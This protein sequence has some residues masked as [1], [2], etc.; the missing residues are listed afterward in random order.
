MLADKD[1]NDKAGANSVL[2]DEQGK[3]DAVEVLTVEGMFSW[4]AA[5]CMMFW[6]VTFICASTMAVLTFQDQGVERISQE[7]SFVQEQNPP[8]GPPDQPR[9]NTGVREINEAFRYHLPQVALFYSAASAAFGLFTVSFFINTML[10]ESQGTARNVDISL[11]CSQGIEV[12]MLRTFPVIL[13][14]L[15]MTGWYVYMTAGWG[16]LL[17]FCAGAFF[18][19]TSA[20]IGIR[21]TV[22]GTCRLA[23]TMGERLDVSVQLGMRT[24]SIGGLLATSLALGG[25]SIMWFWVLDTSLLSGFS[26]GAA[27]VS[28]YLRVGGGI[29]AKGAEIG[30]D[31]VGDMT[32]NANDED[33]RVFELQQRIEDMEIER[34]NRLA[35]GLEEDEED[36]LDL[37]RM[38]EEEMH[39]IC[40]DMHP[41]DFLDEIGEVICDV[42]GT[43]VDLF[44]SMVLILSTAVIIGAKIA[45]VPHFLTGLPFWIV[46]SG[47]IGCS[48]AAYRVHVTE[49][50]TTQMVRWSMRFNLF[51]IIVFTQLVQIGISYMEWIRGSITFRMFINFVV[52]STMGQFLP[53]MCV[54]SGEYFTSPDY[55]PVKSIAENSKLGVVQVTLQGLGQGFLSTTLPAIFVVIAVMVTWELE[56]HYGL[57]LLSSSS[58]SGTG[59]QGGV[60]SFGAVSVCAHK[61]VQ[62]TTYNSMTRNRANICATL[63]DSAMQAGNTVSAINAFSAVF[64][65][66][67]TLLAQS[68]TRQNENYK[69]VSGPPLSEWSQAGLVLGVVMPLLF[70]ANTTL[71]CLETSKSFMR[72]CK[73][74]DAVAIVERQPFPTSHV[75][76]LRILTSFGT[77]TSMRMTFSPLINT[78]ACP[79]LGG[80]FLGIRGL[81]F[82]LSGA[83]VLVMCFSLFL[84]NSGQSWVSA[85][86][87]VLFGHLKGPDGRSVGPDSLQYEHLG[88]GELIGGPLEDTTGPALNNFIKLVGVFAFVT[89]N[90]Y[91]TTPE[92]TWQFGAFVL[93]GSLSL[94]FV[95]RWLLACVLGCVTN[96]IERRENQRALNQEKEKARRELE[97]VAD[98]D[99]EDDDDR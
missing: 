90:L 59:F 22:Q 15:L 99:D 83:N 18:N 34:Q 58:V 88:V 81:I 93:V 84:I 53:E 30:G 79:M 87:Y 14:F 5:W 11:L 73:E 21:T 50:Y 24:G 10:L 17:C 94:V 3:Q 25:M 97:F 68:Y 16:T 37:L 42:T 80:Y 64:N 72:F 98:D 62:L 86:K 61:H 33:R 9:E 4:T 48:V 29:F 13:L 67:V 63:G 47:N 38:M 76:G 65:I 40:S 35:K 51:L 46:A 75:K 71:S 31:L 56:G 28:F 60:A 78:V 89:D 82:M 12:Y 27:I 49:R 95:S 1:K 20:W 70:T 74:S 96:Y 66:T 41:I 6:L 43:C 36:M 52:I 32:E 44:E 69:A 54:M 45:P 26:S 85:R 92:E 7:I 2:K 23:T 19:M 8:Y 39:D 77:V 91:D 55:W 57:A